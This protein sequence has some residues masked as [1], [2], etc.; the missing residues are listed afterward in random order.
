MKVSKQ[1]AR[2]KQHALPEIRF[3]DQK[4]TSHAGASILQLLFKRLG[5]KNRLSKC[6]EH[7]DGDS[8]SYGYGLMALTL[9]VH[10]FLGKR[11]LQ[12][13]RYYE[14]DPL[15]CR[16]LGVEN[17]PTCSTVSR[18]LA[19]LDEISVSKVRGC[20]R[21]IILQ[22]LK[23]E[24]L[25]RVTLDFDGSVLSTSRKAQGTA[26]GYNK[27]KK[28]QRSYYP[29]FCTIAQT[30]Q[31]FD[32]WHRP[33]NV[34]DSNGATEFTLS[35]IAAIKSTLPR[36]VIEIRMDSAFFCEDLVAALHKERIEFSI[37][38]PFA[39]YTNLKAIIEKR[40]R[41]RKIDESESFFESSWKP[42]SWSN[43]FRFVFVRNFVKVQ[44]KGPVQLDMF[45]PYDGKHEFKVIVTNKRI[46]AKKLIQYH[47]GRGYQENIFSEMKS[48][49]QMD[50]IPARHLHANQM[51]LLAS[52]IVHN[53]HRE[54]QMI[55]SE[56][57]RG[58]TEKRSP[59]WIFEKIDTVRSNLINIAG[60]LTRPGGRLTM[61]MNKNHAVETSYKSI[62]EA[63]AA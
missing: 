49:I 25:P 3:Q 56:P 53:T 48:Q 39:R 62:M 63:L 54:M 20:N 28:G 4:L 45:C 11:K 57:V 10:L 16:L 7:L 17:I 43:N 59:R 44:Q 36:A 9:V 52:I 12:D 51:Y 5:L 2:S 26:V 15:V 50:Y 30:G 55:C 1:S 40:K 22:R 23:E 35:C 34:H 46:A 47:N 61:T 33:G 14:N 32:V 6:F 37:S 41:W 58:T 21:D 27:K 42:K 19:E 38:V 60:R 24:H 18:R 8:L 13:I 29:L 31:V